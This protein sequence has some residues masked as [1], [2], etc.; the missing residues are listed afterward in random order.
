MELMVSGR[1]VGGGG[2]GSSVFHITVDMGL[3]AYSSYKISKDQRSTPSELRSCM[4]VDVDV[5]GSRP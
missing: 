4:K 2:G 1:G 5:L 3:Q